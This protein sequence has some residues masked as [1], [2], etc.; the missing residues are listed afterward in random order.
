MGTGDN[1]GTRQRKLRVD[2]LEIVSGALGP[3][4]STTLHIRPLTVFVGPQGSGKSLV[5]QVLYALEE[6]PFLVHVA[7]LERGMARRTDEGVFRWIL[8]HLRSPVRAFGV[9]A[10]PKVTLRWTRGRDAEWP[11]DA[12][13]SFKFSMYGATRQVNLT[14]PERRF[15]ASLR[16]STKS[17]RSRRQLHHAIYFPTE[18]LTISGRRFSLESEPLT[19]GLFD[20]WLEQHAQGAVDGWGEAG[21]PDEDARAIEALADEALAGRGRKSGGRWIWEFGRG[22]AR[23]AFDLDMSSSGQR[24]NFSLP[25]VAKT[26]FSLR[27][28]GDIA[29][30]LTLLVEEPELCLHP[31]A[32]IATVRMFGLLVNRGFRVVVTTHSLTLLYA[33]NNLLQA[34]LVEGEREGLPEPRYRLRASDV[35]VYAF[36]PNK[37]PQELI[38]REQAFIDERE[39]GRVGDELSGE[40]SRIGAHLPP[41]S[42]A[43]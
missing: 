42:G 12:P 40:L 41:I 8:D 7:G 13:P 38:D 31:A 28:T 35:A 15:V 1:G 14:A 6:L 30:T 43:R 10:N 33:L 25:F 39:L 32:Q 22:R 19:Y 11:E 2:R 26:L 5:A 16:R 21:P 37:K 27:G 24:A 20:H 18:R 9:F 36:H 4:P 17:R 23:K 3:V 34:G 29:E